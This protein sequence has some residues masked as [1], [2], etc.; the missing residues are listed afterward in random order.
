MRKNNFYQFLA[1]GFYSGY[2]RIFPGGIGALIGFIIALVFFIFSY[3][4]RLII[5]L[6]FIFISFFIADW[7][8]K[9]FQKKDPKQVTIDEISGVLVGSLFVIKRGQI[10]LLGFNIPINILLLFWVFLLFVLFDKV[11]IFPANKIQKLPGGL[12]IVLDDLIVGLYVGI[13]ILFLSLVI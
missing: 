9:Y 3:Y 5:I 13:I 7:A 8:E 11:K 10:F 1:T 12:G 2:S 4:L 6:I